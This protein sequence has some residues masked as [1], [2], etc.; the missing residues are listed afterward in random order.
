[1]SYAIGASAPTTASQIIGGEVISKTLDYM[2]N[3]GASQ[4]APFDKQT[5]GAAVVSKTLDY[6]NSNQN[7]WGRSSGFNADYDFQKSVLSAAY[8]PVGAVFGAKA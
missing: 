3:L 2:N 1:M 4:P 5:F 6:M 7:S 8:N